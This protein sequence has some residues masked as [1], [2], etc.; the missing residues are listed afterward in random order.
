MYL[1]TMNMKGECCCLNFNVE[2]FGGMDT[3]YRTIGTINMNLVTWI[4]EA[5]KTRKPSKF[6]KL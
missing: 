1:E 6:T 5:A 4:N 3:K 2:N